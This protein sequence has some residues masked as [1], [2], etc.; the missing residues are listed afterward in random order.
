[1]K[2][3]S[4]FAVTAIV[5]CVAIFGAASIARAGAADEAAIK[6]LEDRF[7]KA[8]AA[9]DVGAI[10]A[11]YEHSADLIVF[12]LI[13]PRQYVGWD[14]YKKDWQG[15]MDGCKGPAQVELSDL[16]VSTDSH[17]AFGHNIQHFSCTGADGKPLDLTM[18]V[19]DGYRKTN[20]KWL[21]AHEHISV[22]VDLA[23]GKGDLTSKP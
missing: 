22:P 8:A 3:L 14:A 20:G 4:G 18:R 21:I 19:T 23:T 9:K 10:M 6:A 11:N 13:P 7:A 15:V 17:L 12:D 1:M 5:S 16:S 2:K